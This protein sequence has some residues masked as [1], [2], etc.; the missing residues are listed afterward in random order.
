MPCWTERS[1]HPPSDPTAGVR[2]SE[3]PDGVD[4]SPVG[5]LSQTVVLTEAPESWSRRDRTSAVRAARSCWVSFSACCTAPMRSTN[6]DAKAAVT[7]HSSAMPVTI[8]PTH[9]D[10]PA[11]AGGGDPV[12][13]THGRDGGACPPQRIGERDDVRVVASPLGVEDGQCRKVTRG[14]N[15]LLQPVLILVEVAGH[16]WSAVVGGAASHD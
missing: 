8:N 12:P 10:E 6:Y 1:G 7:T 4:F 2:L 5:V 3:I 16:A 13:V 14:L 15:R 9:P 11:L